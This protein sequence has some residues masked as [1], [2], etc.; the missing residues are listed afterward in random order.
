MAEKAF[1]TLSEA[2]FSR[3]IRNMGF[4]PMTHGRVKWQNTFKLGT[5]KSDLPNIDIKHGKNATGARWKK[6]QYRNQ[7]LLINWAE[8]D[9]EIPG[10]GKTI[11]LIKKFN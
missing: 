7:K 3:F 5:W 1:K 9:D 10:W 11:D 6:S 2:G 4:E 8:S